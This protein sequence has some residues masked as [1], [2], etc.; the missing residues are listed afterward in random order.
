MSPEEEPVLTLAVNTYLTQSINQM[1]LKV[2]SPT[3]KIVNLFFT[4]TNSNDE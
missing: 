3:I 2:N 4:I 1:V